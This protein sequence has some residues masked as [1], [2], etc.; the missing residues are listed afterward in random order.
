[1]SELILTA[2]NFD[3]HV[4]A[5]GK[6]VFVDFWAPWCGPCKIMGPLVEQLAGEVPD[7]V[8][9]KLNVDEHPSLAQRFNVLSIPTFIIFKGGKPVDQFSGTMTKE[10]LKARLQKHI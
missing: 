8:V 9:G 7:A 2:E 4:L 6:P 1:M 10:A 3:Q 5:G